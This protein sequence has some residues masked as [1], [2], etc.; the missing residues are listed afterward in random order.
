MNRHSK[1]ASFSLP[2]NDLTY[3]CGVATIAQWILLRLPSCSLVFES[4][5]YHLPMLLS[6]VVKLLL[7]LSLHCE[8]NENKQKLI[9]ANNIEP[10]L[11]WTLTKMHRW[12]LGNKF[13]SI[14]KELKTNFDLA[15]I[16]LIS[17]NI[18]PVWSDVPK[19][20]HLCKI[21]LNSWVT[22]MNVYS[23]FAKV[24]KFRFGLFASFWGNIF[25]C[26]KQCSILY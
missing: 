24:Q 16:E 15:H 9:V 18:G 14:S 10:A 12:K 3:N 13:G 25:H 22:K 1:Q 26:F 8:K 21:V 20:T 23:A 11:E 19:L 4:Q 7:Y 5:A 6:F 2:E 17:F